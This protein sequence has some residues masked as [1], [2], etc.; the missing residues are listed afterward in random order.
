MFGITDLGVFV[1]GTIAIILLPGP[2][3]IYVLT[4]AARSG[5][6][7]GYAG[8][9]GVFVGDSL[10][11]LLTALGAASVLQAHPLLFNAVR[12]VGAAYLAYLGIKLI[13]GAWRT[14]RTLRASGPLP[15]QQLLAALKPVAETSPLGV[16]RKALFISLFNPKAILFFLSFFVQFV[17]PAYPHPALS[18]LLLGAIVQV[19]SLL[20]LSLLIFAGVR[21]AQAFAGRKRLSA[22]LNTTVGLLFVAFGLRLAS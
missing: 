5:V 8:A 10:L 6:R 4:V 9:L 13:A 17:D 12:W 20:Y 18:F 2:N 7:H 3:S 19:A 21:L 14:V 15:P 1:A 22:L 11:M 16:G